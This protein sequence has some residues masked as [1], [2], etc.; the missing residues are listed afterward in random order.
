MFLEFKDVDLLEFEN[1]SVLYGYVKC[2][3]KVV[4]NVV[5]LLDDVFSFVGY[6]EELGRR[7]KVC[8]LKLLYFDVRNNNNNI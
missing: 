5:F 1:M 8:V 4:E 3:M 7:Y 2:V 6:L